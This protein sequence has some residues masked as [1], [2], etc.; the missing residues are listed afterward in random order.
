MADARIVL[1]DDTGFG[2]EI[3]TA[4][5]RKLGARCQYKQHWRAV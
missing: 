2:L 4:T 1:E 3:V 5:P